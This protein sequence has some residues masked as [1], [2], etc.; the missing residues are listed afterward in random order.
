MRLGKAPT[1]SCTV[2]P[3]SV[4]TVQLVLASASPPSAETSFS[5]ASAPAC[6]ITAS[7][8]LPASTSMSALTTALIVAVAADDVIGA[9]GKPEH[10]SRRRPRDDGDE[11]AAGILLQDLEGE[12][13]GRDLLFV[14][15]DGA[16]LQAAGAQHEQFHLLVVQNRD[17][18]CCAG[19]AEGGVDQIVAGVERDRSRAAARRRDQRQ[20]AVLAR[21]HAED[22]PD[23]AVPKR[24]GPVDEA[25]LQR[26]PVL[27][28]RHRRLRLRQFGR[29]VGNGRADLVLRRR[30]A[31]IL[32]RGDEARGKNVERGIVVL[33][34]R[35]DRRKQPKGEDEDRS[36]DP[37][38][39]PVG[40][41]IRR[42]AF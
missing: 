31:E 36:R 35:S 21:L 8:S 16:E 25:R 23:H 19:A 20:L 40:P 24:R 22:A 12:A 29:H 38:H 37:G 39:R 18:L 26:H 9:G 32:D 5:V 41:L 33:L 15:D 28:A 27:A 2:A 42:M 34:G 14:A 4:M 6:R 7:V 30:L 10:Q 13:V 11:V 3:A 1:L 17:A